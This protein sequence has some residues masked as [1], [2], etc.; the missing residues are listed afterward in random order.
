MGENRER[1]VCSYDILVEIDFANCETRKSYASSRFYATISSNSS[2]SFIIRLILYKE[3]ISFYVLPLFSSSILL[4][5][6]SFCFLFANSFF[7][8]LIS[9][10]INFV[11]LQ[12]DTLFVLP[13]SILTSWLYIRLVYA[14]C[15]AVHNECVYQLV[16][17]V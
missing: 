12:V 4:F 2:L 13:V 1:M 6:L 5:Q 3:C 8:L 9:I 15:R 17:S 7:V 10:S 16:V 14:Y 11:P